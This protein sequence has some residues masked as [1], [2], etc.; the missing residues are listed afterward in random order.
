MRK[1]K[2]G[3][4]QPGGLPFDAKLDCLSDG[5]IN[6]VNT[7]IDNHV[8]PNLS[9][10]LSLLEECG[11]AGCTIVTSCEDMTSLGRYLTAEPSLYGELA[12][13]ASEIVEDKLSAL[14]KK[15][16]MYIIGCYAKPE[17]NLIYNTASLFNPS[18]V[19]IGQYHK[20]HLPP[21]EMWQITEGEKINVIETDFGKIGIEICY[22]MMFSEPT[23]VLSLLGADVIFHPTAGYGW[24][25]SIG[26]ATLRTRA[27]DGSV[28]IVTAKNYIYNG[29]GKSSVIDRWGQVL[30]DAGF[31]ENTIVYK[32][33]DLELPKSQPDWFYP[34]N[35]SGIA[36][37]KR[38][39]L[40]ERR[41]ELYGK[42]LEKHSVKQMPPDETKKSAL[43]EK[44]KNGRCRWN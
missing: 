31:Y 26:E 36:D 44:I 27:N 19:I 40:T 7:I 25:D 33:I 39:K 30:A 20:T 16:R 35:M 43:R 37:V 2:V 3:A 5:F 6:D 21:D 38:R 28:F 4:I 32:E 1:I 41:P 24:Y 9:I 12:K 34:T 17:G 15:Y 29:A 10:S 8:L 18:G 23:E 22:D 42:L 11:K 13:S 14:A